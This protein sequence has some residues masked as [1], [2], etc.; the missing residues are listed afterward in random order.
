MEPYTV[1]ERA[2]MGAMHAAI[3]REHARAAA[4]SR[5]AKL[6][7][8]I[9]DVHFAGVHLFAGTVFFIPFVV[10]FGDPVAGGAATVGRRP[11]AP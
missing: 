2:R 11:G 8:G 4:E 9:H 1:R 7:V 10:G 3:E 5:M 6:G